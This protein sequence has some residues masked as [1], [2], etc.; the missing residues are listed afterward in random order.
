MTTKK[1]KIIIKLIIPFFF[2]ENNKIKS[3]KIKSPKEVV[4]SISCQLSILQKKVH[5]NRKDKISFPSTRFFKF[6]FELVHDTVLA[7]FSGFI[8]GSSFLPSHNF[9]AV[10]P[11]IEKSEVFKILRDMPKGGV[12]HAH[13]T[14][15]ASLDYR[16]NNLTYRENL[17]VCDE[18]NTLQLK[19]FNKTD[20]TCDWKLLS[21]VRQDPA[22]ADAINERIRRSLTMI[23]ENPKSVYTTVDKAWQKFDSIFAFMRNLVS[24]RPVYED[25][26]YRNLQEFYEDNIIYA[27]IRSTLSSLYDLDGKTYGAVEMV[28]IH[29]DVTDR[30]NFILRSPLLF[31]LIFIELNFRELINHLEVILF[32]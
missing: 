4:K 7:L 30:L 9:M 23:T 11:R 18:N 12:L 6:N 22:R 16:L 28:Q 29:K 24:Y 26:Y 19:F 5:F 13:E 2:N 14:A 27:E 20:D 25:L 10:I 31:L 15:I 21:E 32:R 17:Y 8:T 1:Q 3:N